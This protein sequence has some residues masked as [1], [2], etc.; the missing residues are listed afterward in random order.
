MPSVT[1]YLKD[2]E[3]SYPNIYHGD[4]SIINFSITFTV[5]NA[6]ENVGNVYDLM[7]ELVKSIDKDYGK[8]RISIED[9]KPA[10]K[11]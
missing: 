2:L 8:I 3:V 1:A 6:G 5:C 10:S 9:T 11:N 4:I 7:D